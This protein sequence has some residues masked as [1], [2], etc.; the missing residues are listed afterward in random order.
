MSNKSLYLI[1]SSYSATPSALSKLA[2][3]YSSED[4]VILMG[5]SVLHFQHTFIQQLNQFYILDRDAEILAS[6][7]LENAIV[8]S[9][10]QFADLCLAY[11]RCIR[12]A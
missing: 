5:E 8:I 3:T 1:Q 4:L 10:E 12:L 2:Q 9:Y 7:I 11:S 6:Q